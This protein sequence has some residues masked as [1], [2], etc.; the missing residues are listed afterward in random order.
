MSKAVNTIA[1]G[2]EAGALKAGA[3]QYMGAVENLP[4]FDPDKESTEITVVE[5]VG[6]ESDPN[7]WE[8]Y[9]TS[10]VTVKGAAE[11]VSDE[12]VATMIV[13]NLGEKFQISVKIE[14]E[15]EFEYKGM[16]LLSSSP[17]ELLTRSTEYTTEMEENT[18]ATIGIICERKQ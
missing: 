4:P 16:Y 5:M 10:K 13:C 9:P 1:R 12:E 14:N 8:E 3:S 6:D 18:G 2:I 17:F 7:T 15:Q 11:V